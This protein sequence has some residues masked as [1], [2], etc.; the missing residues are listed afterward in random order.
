MS[1]STSLMHENPVVARL[2]AENEK[3]RLAIIA[4][5]KRVDSE[6]D[7]SM[8]LTVA[9]SALLCGC[10]VLDRTPEEDF[11]MGVLQTA[12]DRLR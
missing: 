2:R 3:Q 1:E 10:D 7:I 12:R 5:Q 4:L 6:R 9:L 8:S 11:G